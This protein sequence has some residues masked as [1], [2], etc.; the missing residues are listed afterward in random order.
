MAIELYSYESIAQHPKLL[1]LY[2]GWLGQKI[3]FLAHSAVT[4]DQSD[5]WSAAASEMDRL[6]LLLHT[7]LISTKISHEL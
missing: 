5:S 6:A 2:S 4:W 1:A 7:L 3:Y